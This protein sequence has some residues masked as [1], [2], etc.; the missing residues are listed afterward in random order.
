MFILIFSIPTDVLIIMKYSAFFCI[1]AELA[2]QAKNRILHKEN[3]WQHENGMPSEN[4]FKKH[5][6]CAI[7]THVL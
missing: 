5:G 7:A 2:L 1:L 4:F 3:T 6:E